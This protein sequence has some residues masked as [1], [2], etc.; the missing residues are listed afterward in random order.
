[1]TITSTPISDSK[2]PWGLV[3]LFYVTDYMVLV[4]KNIKASNSPKIKNILRTYKGFNLNLKKN[5]PGLYII[6]KGL[7]VGKKIK[8]GKKRKENLGKI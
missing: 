5:F 1:M 6:W 7:E 2:Q 8:G 4:Y 3:S